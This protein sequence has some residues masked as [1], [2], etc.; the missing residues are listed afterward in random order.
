MATIPLLQQG[1]VKKVVNCYGG[2]CIGP[3]SYSGLLLA[4][5]HLHE[6]AAAAAG[7]QSGQLL[8]SKTSKVSKATAAGVSGHAQGHGTHDLA[9]APA[10]WTFKVS[11]G[12][13]VGAA[14]AD[15]LDGALLCSTFYGLIWKP[16]NLQGTLGAILI[17]GLHHKMLYH[18]IASP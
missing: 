5:L 8:A 13:V 18:C 17:V 3:A 15:G 2:Y 7:E 9:L 14:A 4:A 10:R 1:H 11:G 16:A 6:A 12:S